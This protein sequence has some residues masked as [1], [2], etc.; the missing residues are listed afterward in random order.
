[1]RLEDF[2]PGYCT[3]RYL[4]TGA[5]TLSDVRGE[6]PGRSARGRSVA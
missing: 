1:L 4:H 5:T 6:L 2:L 3:V